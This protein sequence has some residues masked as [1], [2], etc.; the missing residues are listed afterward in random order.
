VD[1]QRPG[2]EGDPVPGE[3]G[4]QEGAEPGQVPALPQQLRDV[5][6]PAQIVQPVTP[7]TPLPGGLAPPQELCVEQQESRDE[8]KSYNARVSH[9]GK[10]ERRETHLACGNRS[11]KDSSV[12]RSSYPT[13]GS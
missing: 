2:L 9:K 4:G 11:R 7:C 8:E 10:P 3:L 6:T 5:S 12:N 13:L 1:G